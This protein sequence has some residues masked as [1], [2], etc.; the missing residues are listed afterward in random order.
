MKRTPADPLR[1]GHDPDPPDTPRSRSGDAFVRI[2]SPPGADASTASATSNSH[3]TPGYVLW[4]LTRGHSTAEAR[5]WVTATGLELEL[6]IWT[7][8]RVRG[9]EDLSWVQ[10]FSSEAP[11]ADTAEAKKRQLEAAGWV[12]DIPTTAL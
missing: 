4:T 1:P 5:R 2:P 9:E 12:E 8:S 3:L 6:Q 7:G 10:F 11:L